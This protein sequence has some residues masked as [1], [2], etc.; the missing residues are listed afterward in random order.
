VTIPTVPGSS[1]TTSSS[2]AADRWFEL[3]RD[4]FTTDRLLQA[5]EDNA[6]LLNEPQARNFAKWPVL[7]QYV[8][9]NWFIANT[10]REEIN[11]M[12]GW[13]ANRVTWMDSQVATE[14]APVP[15]SFNRQGGYVSPGFQLAV[16]APS[17]GVCYALDDRPTVARNRPRDDHRSPGVEC[18]ETGACPQWAGGGLAKQRSFDDSMDARDGQS[19]RCGV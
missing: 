18:H 17:G 3:R 19:R 11:W 13:L 2:C 16:S 6:A 8:W 10:W 15:P 9:P 14:F 5:V 12:E 7:G 1:R 4:L